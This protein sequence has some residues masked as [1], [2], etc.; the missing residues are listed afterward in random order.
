M[1]TEKHESITAACKDD[2]G[3]GCGYQTQLG[4]SKDQYQAEGTRETSRPGNVLICRSYWR[5]QKYNMV[6]QEQ[7][8]NIT[9][10]RTSTAF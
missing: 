4:Q 1:V 9:G 5:Q 3:S 6:V 7:A 2:A 10:S 8:C